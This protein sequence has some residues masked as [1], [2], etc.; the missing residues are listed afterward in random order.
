MY[1]NYIS[2]ILH[3]LSLVTAA[4]QKQKTFHRTASLFSPFVFFL[5]FSERVDV[6]NIKFKFIR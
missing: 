1:N 5:F 6:I 4:L 3:S 2:D